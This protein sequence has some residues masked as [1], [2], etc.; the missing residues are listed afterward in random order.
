M[1]RIL[2]SYMFL[3]FSYFLETISLS[4]TNAS[5]YWFFSLLQYIYE[6][7]VIRHWS[8]SRVGPHEFGKDWPST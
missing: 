7:V 3:G 8:L 6:D 4:L 2:G 1:D 5:S